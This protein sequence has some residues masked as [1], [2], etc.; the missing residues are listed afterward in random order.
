MT[1]SF[2]DRA[3][4]EADTEALAQARREGRREGYQEAAA[5]Y[6]EQAKRWRQCYDAL[7]EIIAHC[8]PNGDFDRLDELMREWVAKA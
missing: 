5:E 7:R 8:G 6:A 2:E 1:V 3:L 4:T